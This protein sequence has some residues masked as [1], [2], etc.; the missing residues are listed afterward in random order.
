M[1]SWP[2][3]TKALSFLQACNIEVA[4]LQKKQCELPCKTD[5]CER[6]TKSKHLELDPHQMIMTPMS[7]METDW[8]ML[9]EDVL[10]D[11]S[12]TAS[13]STRGIMSPN[14]NMTWILHMC[15]CLSYT[16]SPLLSKMKSSL[17][18]ADMHGE[19]ILISKQCVNRCFPP[20]EDSAWLCGLNLAVSL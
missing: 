5:I 2:M 16:T 1:V 13:I 14:L 12:G 6:R 20:F 19:Q 15:I 18:L 4:T 10:S 17:D 11:F 7:W 9:W 8:L 3:E